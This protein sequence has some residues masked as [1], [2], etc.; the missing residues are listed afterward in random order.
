[1][2]E[3]HGFHAYREECSVISNSDAPVRYIAKCALAEYCVWEEQNTRCR[4]LF[5]R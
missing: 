2:M 1:M 4:M 3:F 5:G